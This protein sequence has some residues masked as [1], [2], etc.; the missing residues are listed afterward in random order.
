MNHSDSI[1][2]RMTP[3]TGAGTAPR[4]RLAT[5]ADAALLARHRADMFRDMG[6]CNAATYGPLVAASAAYFTRAIPAGE[7][8]GWIATATGSDGC[9]VPI[10]GAGV[11]VRV[12]LPR[13]NETGTELTDGP[14]G[15]VLNVYTEEAWRRR[16]VAEQLMRH[17]LEWSRVRG[18]VRVVLHA[19]ASGRP[20]YEKLG[21]V[22]TNEMRY[23]GTD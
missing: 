4:I 20:L 13:P 2:P 9:D 15:I 6:R 22:A 16:G 1:T 14:E 7:Y 17:L 21:F 5:A 19:S 12:M 23:T 11:Q 18:L 8:A 10:A 3:D